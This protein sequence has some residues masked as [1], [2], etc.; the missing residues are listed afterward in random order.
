M[1][2]KAFTVSTAGIEK[3]ERLIGSLQPALRLGLRRTVEIETIKLQRHVVQEKLS[4]QVLHVRTGTGRRS[5]TYRVEEAGTVIRGIVGTNLVY[6]KAHE[7]GAL[8][9][10]PEIR[11]RNARALHFMVNGV[12]VFAMRAR[13]HTVRLPERS[14]LRT[15]LAER[16]RAF[17]QAIK[18]T[19][20]T[21]FG[22]LK[23]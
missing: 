5:I 13:A 7:Y 23:K 12:S 9:Q 22:S 11:P 4:G 10:V 20:K 1:P 8:I 21:V 3:A 2:P 18:D 16:A 17:R 15:S 14:F 6:M 19:I